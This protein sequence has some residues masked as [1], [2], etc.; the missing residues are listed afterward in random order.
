[1]TKIAIVKTDFS[2]KLYWENLLS[3]DRHYANQYGMMI[4]I[5][6]PG[7]TE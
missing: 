3:A 1:M 2:K 4:F 6:I 5:K 7:I